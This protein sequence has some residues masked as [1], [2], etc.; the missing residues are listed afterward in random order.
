MKRIVLGLILVSIIA[1]IFLTGCT[2][3]TSE[4][5]TP[6]KTESE[7]IEGAE[8]GVVDTKEK[9]PEPTDSEAEV[10]DIGEE[11]PQLTQEEIAV[12]K[13][14]ALCKEALESGQDLSNGPC[15]SDEAQSWDVEDWVCDIAHSP[16]AEVDNL[17]EN[18]CKEFGVSANHFVEFTPECEFIKK[19]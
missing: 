7:E 16:R 5:K 3:Q 18:Q 9:E 4:E 2:Q 14:A 10:K 13:C 6:I 11:T 19:Y 1:L 17:K 12:Q 15:L 8:F